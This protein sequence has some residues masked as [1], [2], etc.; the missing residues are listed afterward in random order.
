MVAT[1][2]ISAL[3]RLMQED[4]HFQAILSHTV[5]LCFKNKKKKNIY[6]YVTKKDWLIF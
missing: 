4:K 3:R 1:P 6:N 5:K 2:V